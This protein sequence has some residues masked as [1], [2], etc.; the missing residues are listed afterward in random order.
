MQLVILGD[1]ACY[2][3]RCHFTG[4]DGARAWEKRISMHVKGNDER[5]HHF[6][7]MAEEG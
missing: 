4:L 5:A 7:A 6:L 1:M 3:G 2:A